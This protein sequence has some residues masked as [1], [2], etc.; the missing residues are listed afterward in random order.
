MAIVAALLFVLMVFGGLAGSIL[1]F[2]WL[3]LKFTG[4]DVLHKNMEGHHQY[5]KKN[6]EFAQLTDWDHETGF[7]ENN[8]GKRKS[9]KAKA[10]P[11]Y[12]RLHTMDKAQKS[13]EIRLAGVD[14]VEDNSEPARMSDMLKDT[15]RS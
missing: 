10:T 7:A 2:R 6:V 15:R 14:A 1:L 11:H 9:R 4:Y 8:R 13:A 5:L 3:M 12:D